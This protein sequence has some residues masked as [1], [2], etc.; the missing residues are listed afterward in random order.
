MGLSTPYGSADKN[1]VI[2]IA[3]LGAVAV[4]L[5]IKYLP[6]LLVDSAGDTVKTVGKALDPTADLDPKTN[7]RAAEVA[8]K[9]FS[10]AGFEVTPSTIHGDNPDGRVFVSTPTWWGLGDN[11]TY[12]YK[13][14]DLADL[15]FMQ[16]AAIQL[17]KIVPGTWLTRG[18]LQ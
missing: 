15:N 18:A 16:K 12:S 5:I 6:K 3:I 8:Q 4:Y 13:T 1:T 7:H 2:V 10:G 9:I 11:V 17:D 14:S